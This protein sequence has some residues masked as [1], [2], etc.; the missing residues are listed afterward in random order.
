M[1]SRV[2]T[3]LTA[4]LLTACA[5]IS[6]PAEAPRVLI[7]SHSTGYRHASI[8][9]A[10]VALRQSSE[11]A[12]YSVEATED[13]DV[14]SAARLANV[15]AIILLDNTTNRQN[16]E[17][18]FFSGARG[19]AFQAFVRRGGGV[20]AIHGASGGHP[21]WPW[22]RQ[23]L[24]AFF[25]RHPPGEQDGRVTIVSPDHPATRGLPTTFVRHDEWYYFIDYDP[26]VR[27][28]ATWDPASIGEPD[29][30]PNPISW[31]HE[32]E[33]GRVFYTGMGHFAEHYREP[34]FKAHLAGALRWVLRLEE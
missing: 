20:V 3:L 7:F 30:N 14:F 11:E 29:V 8:E 17:T 2:V 19:E 12:G 10:V 21:N 9:E 26:T 24:G 6:T 23:M 16:P 4:V 32:F 31:V 33:G 22:Y 5:S 25:E 18:D 13:P 28:L 15:D 27:V 34:I 1:L